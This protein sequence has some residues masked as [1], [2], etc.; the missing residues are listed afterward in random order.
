MLTLLTLLACPKTPTDVDTGPT[1]GWKMEQDWRHACFHPA[2]LSDAT[3][4]RQT[5][6]TVRAMSAQWS[7]QKRDGVSF[8]EG[9][10]TELTGLL[11]AKD[12]AYVNGVAERNLEL[13]RD[14]MQG[15]STTSAWGSYLEALRDEL[16][17]EACPEPLEDTFHTLDLSVGWQADVPLCPG[18]SVRIKASTADLY[19]VSADGEFVR[20]L[21]DGP[22]VEGDPCMDMDCQHGMLVGRF[23]GASGDEQVFAVG[24]LLEWTAPEAGTLSVAINDSDL[25][26]NTWRLEEGVRDGITVEFYALK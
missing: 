19:R 13:C 17:E 12:A 6:D 21:G 11:N 2:P 8:D 20:V 23:Q 15:G 4:D 22:A 18:E 9:L 25:S 16:A 7:G 26:D 10:V 5:A 24:A 14:V 3:T 1:Y